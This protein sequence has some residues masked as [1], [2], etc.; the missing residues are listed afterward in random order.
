MS[1]DPIVLPNVPCPEWCVTDHRD[2]VAHLAEPGYVVSHYGATETFG[3]C[4]I[5]FDDGEP[6]PASLHPV[7]RTLAD[8]SEVESGMVLNGRFLDQPAMQAL[9]AGLSA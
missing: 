5:A 9:A 8:G 3:E 1:A 6:R 2:D 4:T 7:L